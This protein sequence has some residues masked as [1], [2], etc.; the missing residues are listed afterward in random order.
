M[1]PYA[2]PPSPESPPKVHASRWA[3]MR[4]GLLGGCLFGAK[5]ALIVS[6]SL[7]LLI[8]LAYIGMSAYRLAQAA[9]NQRAAIELG[10]ILIAAVFLL[11][12]ISVLV[13]LAAATLGA[14]IAGLWNLIAYRRL[15]EP[16]GDET[17]RP[18]KS[19]EAW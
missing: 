3:A 19:K 1:N 8:S 16:R 4:A 7:T 15:G 6:G 11:L 18:A 10:T 17:N 9:G 2:A 14:L 12:L 5:W 13:T